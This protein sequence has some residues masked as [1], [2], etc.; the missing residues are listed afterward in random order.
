MVEA[1]AW[2][3]PVF[4]ADAIAVL[5]YVAQLANVVVLVTCTLA[6]P[7]CARSPKAQPSV[8]FGAEPLTEQVPGPP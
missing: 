3:L 5:L 7:L 8:W 6:E 4:V 2:A 1:D